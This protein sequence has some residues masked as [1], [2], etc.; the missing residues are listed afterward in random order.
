L[1]KGRQDW[2]AEII[3][4]KQFS[5]R[6]MAITFGSRARVGLI[7]PIDNVVIE[8]ELYAVGVKGVS[9]H[10][11]RLTTTERWIMAEQAIVLASAFAESGVDLIVYCCAE[12]GFLGPSDLSLRVAEEVTKSTGIPCVTAVSGMISALQALG[13]KRLSL[14]APY[15]AARTQVMQEVLLHHGFETVGCVHRDFNAQLADPREWY[16]TNRQPSSVAYEMAK[17]ADEPEADAVLVTGTNLR[18]LAVITALEAELGKPVITSNQAI[19]WAALR[20]LG[21][22][23]HIPD[24][25]RLF[26]SH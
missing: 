26:Q 20:H 1:D 22:T 12:T 11:V 23:D 2:V 24:L 10:T 4:R 19:L 7:V 17:L 25:G 3:K 21:I 16:Q 15:T 5:G 9:F 13:M 18:T 6:E 14:V 8:P